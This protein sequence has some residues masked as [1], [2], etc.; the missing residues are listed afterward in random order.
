MPVLEAVR[1]ARHIGPFCLTCLFGNGVGPSCW[2]ES[3]DSI[4]SA[5]VVL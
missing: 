2:N 4:K 3:Y 5:F 1:N